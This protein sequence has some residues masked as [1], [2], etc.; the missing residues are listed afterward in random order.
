MCNYRQRCAVVRKY[1]KLW[2]HVT[3]L[4]GV[5]RGRVRRG[6][7]TE[8]RSEGSIKMN[9]VI[10]GGRGDFPGRVTVHALFSA[11]RNAVQSRT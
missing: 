11:R 5:G 7:S 4:T 3:D 2:Q 1:L 6:F 8:L 10:D 9:T